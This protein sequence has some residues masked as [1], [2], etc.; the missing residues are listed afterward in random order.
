[1]VAGGWEIETYER[2]RNEDIARDASY[3]L[4]EPRITLSDR[5][6]LIDKKM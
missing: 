2:S 1:M 3:L 5:C 4:C 6:F